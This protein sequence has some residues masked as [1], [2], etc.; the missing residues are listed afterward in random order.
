MGPTAAPRGHRPRFTSAY[1]VPRNASASRAKGHRL[2]DCLLTVEQYGTAAFFVA[3]ASQ[4][5]AVI[6]TM[7]KEKAF[8]EVPPGATVD[9]ITAMIESHFDASAFR[10]DA[11]LWLV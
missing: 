10:A 3:A 8:F 2:T 11:K 1:A 7:R 4:E 9:S 5:F 6:D